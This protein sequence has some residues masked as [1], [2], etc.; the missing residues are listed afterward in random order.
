VVGRLPVR[1]V[2]VI[3]EEEIFR[4]GVVACLEHDPS[5]EI[6]FS[7][8]DGPLEQEADVAVTSAPVVARYAFDCPVVVCTDDPPTSVRARHAVVAAVLP[9]TVSQEQLVAAVSATA[10]GLTIG[11]RGDRPAGIEEVRLDSRLREVLRLLADGADTATISE[12]LCYSVRTV[13]S[14]IQELEHELSATS[15]AQAVARGIRGGII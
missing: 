14:F 12:Q 13:K 5:F 3:D 4:R 10:A 9:R 2:A 7:A 6:V 15:R 11:S 8:S 1:R